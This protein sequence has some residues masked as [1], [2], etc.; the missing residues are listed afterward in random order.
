[1]AVKV[2]KPGQDLRFDVPAV[3]PETVDV[4]VGAGII[5]LALEAGKTLLL[6]RD[7]LLAKARTTS[8]LVVGIRADGI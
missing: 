1:V 4:C 6:D 5:V 3:G 7:T 8:L 2:S